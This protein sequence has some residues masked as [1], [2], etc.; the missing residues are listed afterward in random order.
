MY[1]D[2]TKRLNNII[3]ELLELTREGKIYV[4]SQAKERLQNVVSGIYVL[5]DEQSVLPFKKRE[6]EKAAERELVTCE[7]CKAILQKRNLESH[8]LNKCPK[9]QEQY[10]VQND[11]SHFITCTKCGKHLLKKNYRHHI[12]VGC[13]SLKYPTTKNKLTTLLKNPKKDDYSWYARFFGKKK[14]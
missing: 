5:Q 2:R 11:D 14:F 13:D 7:Y 3:D 1:C 4:S 9:K 8:L 12:E 10:S 6:A